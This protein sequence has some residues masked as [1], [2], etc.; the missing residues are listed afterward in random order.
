MKSFK[1]RFQELRIVFLVTLC[2]L[3][4]IAFF[5]CFSGG[6]SGK[7]SSEKD[8][9]V[10]SADQIKVVIGH[11]YD[12][13][14][15]YAYSPEIK[16][17]ILDYDRLNADGKIVYNTNLAEGDFKTVSGNTITT[18]QSSLAFDA[19]VSG[20][21]GVEGAS[22]TAE[23]GTKFNKEKYQSDEYA[24]ATSTSKITKAGYYIENRGYPAE[25]IDYLTDQFKKDVDAMNSDDLIKKYGTHVMLGGVW[26]AR[27]DYDIVVKK[28][29]SNVSSQIGA[30]ANAK[31]EAT[32]GPAS[33][34]AGANLNVDNQY[35]NYFEMNTAEIR[36]HAY[37][38]A[39]EYAQSIQNKGDYDAWIATISDNT[40]WSDYYPD[41]LQPIYEFITDPS[42][43][44]AVKTAYDNY[45]KGKVITVTSSTATGFIEADFN[46]M[47]F[48]SNTKGDG[49][50]NSKSERTTRYEFTIEVNQ[51]GTDLKASIFLRITEVNGDT[52]FEGPVDVKIPATVTGITGNVNIV[53]VDLSPNSYSRVGEVKFQQLDWLEMQ[54][55]P[56]PSF[57]TSVSVKM[58]GSGDDKNNIG[59]KGHFKIPVHYKR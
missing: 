58:D 48:T 49:E 34:N 38:G 44:E 47:G 2:L 50:V 55:P 35:T 53:S 45:L 10:I 20:G 11:G 22:F 36:T 25:Q 31:F 21:G 8:T 7:D 13:T 32:Y 16:S 37:G 17:S 56:L 42:K 51:D 14:G 29:I 46:E 15:R 18:Y 23:V 4:S 59:I 57:L 12:V 33:V 52:V 41:S 26:G 28:K 39:V 1:N 27:L 43:K 3:M 40:V 6:G 30:Y 5:S 19:G 54:W 24:F 9:N